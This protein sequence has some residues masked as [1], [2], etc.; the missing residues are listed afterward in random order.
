MS[1]PLYQRVL[2]KLSGEALLGD[3][4]YG[5]D[6]KVLR[7]I[8]GEIREVSALGCGRLHPAQPIRGSVICV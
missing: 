8:A 1:D 4:D 6:A 7:R 2:L 3:V 5:I